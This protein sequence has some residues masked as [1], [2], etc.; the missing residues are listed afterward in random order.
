M[1]VAAQFFF[2]LYLLSQDFFLHGVHSHSNKNDR[3]VF[4]LFIFIF[5][6]P[7]YP[8]APPLPQAYKDFS[9][10]EGSLI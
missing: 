5:F 3:H 4:D 9:N 1:H 6:I 7:I 10:I 8:A 2:L